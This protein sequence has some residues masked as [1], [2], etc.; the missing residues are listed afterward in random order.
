VLV[1]SGQ[2]IQSFAASIMGGI[3]A[4]AE[5]VVGLTGVAASV[6]TR[7]G[8]QDLPGLPLPPALQGFQPSVSIY[9]TSSLQLL[10]SIHAST[11]FGYTAVALSEDGEL[12]AVCGAEPD[13]LLTVWQWRKVRVC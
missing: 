6:S 3:I 11:A 7:Q 2:G 4:V 9:A 5:Q 13:L 8:P 1:T 10:Q 12:L